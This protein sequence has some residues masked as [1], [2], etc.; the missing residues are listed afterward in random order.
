MLLISKESARL[1]CKGNLCSDLRP[2]FQS[3]S[4][5]MTITSVLSMFGWTTL[6]EDFA[7]LECGSQL[8]RLTVHREESSE[9][10]KPVEKVMVVFHL[11]LL[12]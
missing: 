3:F 10:N 1:F 5:Q 12:L 11:Q 9:F 2:A 8:Q 7:H 6:S 4:N